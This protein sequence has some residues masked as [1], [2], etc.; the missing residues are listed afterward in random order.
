MSFSLKPKHLK[1]Y[2]DIALL[3]IKHGRSDVVKHI[4]L[5]DAL[6]PDALVETTTG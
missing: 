4:E 2:K 1:R 3:L 5:E 6:E